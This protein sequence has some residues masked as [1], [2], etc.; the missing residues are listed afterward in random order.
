V[1]ERSATAQ[2]KL[3]EQTE[4]VRGKMAADAERLKTQLSAQ[5]AQ[6]PSD[7]PAPEA[8]AA[9]PPVADEPSQ[10]WGGPPR[11][12]ADDPEAGTSLL[13]GFAEGANGFGRAASDIGTSFMSSVQAATKDERECGLTRAQRF[14]WYVILL[15]V[16]TGFFSLSLNFLPLAIIKPSK[17]AASFCVGTVAC[18]AAKFMLNG[19]R[20]Q[21][22]LM[23]AWRKLPYS[24]ALVASTA[25]TM[26]SCFVL[27]NF[28]A[29]VVASAMQVAALLYYLF[30]DTPGGIAG[31]KLLGRLVFKTARLIVAPCIA[32]LSGD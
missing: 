31:I 16:A 30:G 19:P 21:L 28:L 2:A 5:F 26:Y 24:L 1:D 13:S 32:A 3:A 29:V 27:G 20:T 4:S 14:R 6:A 10:W 12:D 15:L 11:A 17:F 18:I 8:V 23:V 7:A 25:L 22:K 9:A